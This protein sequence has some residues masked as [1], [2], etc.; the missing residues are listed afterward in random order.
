MNN[1]F[2][3]LDTGAMMGHHRV[4]QDYSG[5]EALVE[6][7]VSTLHPDVTSHE[8][9]IADTVAVKAHCVATGYS[10][11]DFDISQKSVVPGTDTIFLPGGVDIGDVQDTDLVLHCAT[12]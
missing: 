5:A 6:S 7:L 8:W 11:G 3:K 4:D 10:T 9:A 1:I 2:I 12:T